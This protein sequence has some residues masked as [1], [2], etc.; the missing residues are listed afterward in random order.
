MLLVHHGDFTGP[1]TGII[2]WGCDLSVCVTSDTLSRT[3]RG[4]QKKNDTKTWSLGEH[5]VGVMLGVR[6]ASSL[7]VIAAVVVCGI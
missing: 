6:A 7:T 3:P 2:E 1:T 4:N 5:K